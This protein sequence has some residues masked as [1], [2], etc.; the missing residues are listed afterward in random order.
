MTVLWTEKNFPS[1]QDYDALAFGNGLFV[2]VGYQSNDGYISIDGNV[3]TA[4]TFPTVGAYDDWSS[5]VWSGTHFIFS[6]PSN[7]FARSSDGISWSMVDLTGQ[8]GYFNLDYGNLCSDDNGTVI[9]SFWNRDT[10]ATS[11]DHGATWTFGTFGVGS[12]RQ[13]IVRFLD[14]VFVV[15]GALPPSYTFYAAT[16]SD[17]LT[18]SA[19]SVITGMTNI[20]DMAAGNGVFV[21]LGNSA[22]DH[23]FVSSDGVSW[24][25][26]ALPTTSADMLS[27][28]GTQFLAM[29]G[30]GQ[31]ATSP[32]GVNWTL[33]PA[34]PTAGG[35]NYYTMIGFP[36]GF[37]ATGYGNDISFTGTYTPP[38][39]A[40]TGFWTGFV[41]CGAL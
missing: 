6:G 20:Q 17:G 12:G 7:G 24:A 1:T 38:V 32:D 31:G 9:A 27:F 10:F 37:A 40:P 13:H 35:S 11:K 16:S 21:V 25:E 19:P 36:G 5:G 29:P 22:I 14:G 3:W 8:A 33:C 28:D 18:W 15:V 2:A 23:V 26:H 4:V 39:T 41:G 30:S 34:L